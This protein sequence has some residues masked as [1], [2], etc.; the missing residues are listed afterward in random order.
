IDTSLTEILKAGNAAFAGAQF[1]PVNVFSYGLFACGTSARKRPNV[2]D[3]KRSRALDCGSTKLNPQERRRL[4]W[5][6]RLVASCRSANSWENLL[7]GRASRRR[8]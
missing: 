3:L 2:S 7:R 1:S 6:G 8:N 5:R 4:G